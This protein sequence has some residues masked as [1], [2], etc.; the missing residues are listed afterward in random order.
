MLI[1]PK[2]TL[3]FNNEWLDK[4]KFQDH[5]DYDLKGNCSAIAIKSESG[6]VYD[7]YRSNPIE[8]PSTFTLTQVYHKVK[9]VRKI[10]DYFS[11]IETTRV[12]IHKS[13]PGHII[14]LHTDDNNVQA[15]EKEDY[16]LRIITALNDDEDF[17]YIYESEGIRH[18]I[19]LSKGQSIIFDP[20][21]VKHGLINNS[22]SKA[23]YALVQIFKA[24]PVHRGLIDFINTDQLKEI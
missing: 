15:K 20:D 18:N 19:K 4:L 9:E 3:L 5:T 2:T 23:R 8:H 12:R 22:K 7:F 6:S 21:K 14:K 13:D 1:L 24:Y 16:R 11:F 10:I 17:T